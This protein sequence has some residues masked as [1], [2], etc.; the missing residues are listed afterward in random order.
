MH[1]LIPLPTAG[2]SCDICEGRIEA[3]AISY[4]CQYCSP[5]VCKKCYGDEVRN[6]VLALHDA[7]I[8]GRSLFPLPP[9]TPTPTHIQAR[10]LTAL[11]YR[12]K[13]D[14]SFEGRWLISQ[15]NADSKTIDAKEEQAL[16][17]SL[18][19]EILPT[20]H[21][22]TRIQG[23][24][25]GVGEGYIEWVKVTSGVRHTLTRI[26]GWLKVRGGLLSSERSLEGWVKLTDTYID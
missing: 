4:T 23:C 21:T 5:T 20:V 25:E 19:A 6:Y 10:G 13:D 12:S 18:V 3:G 1:G 16:I 15:T 24:L 14:G 17:K 26:Q 22:Y 7:Y 9:H 8:C 2:W 11:L